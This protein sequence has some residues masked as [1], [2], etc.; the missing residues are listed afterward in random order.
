MTQLKRFENFSTNEHQNTGHAEDPEVVAFLAQNI[1]D[2]R[3]IEGPDGLMYKGTNVF[4]FY[5]SEEV[6]QELAE[7]AGIGSRD[8]E[9]DRIDGQEVYLGYYPELD[10]F[11]C[12]FDM[13]GN[14]G[15]G[16]YFVYFKIDDGRLD[17][18]SGHHGEASGI[19][20]PKNY[21]LLHSGGPKLIDIRLD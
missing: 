13:F 3:G 17:I 12:G 7:K 10:Q 15:G 16:S 18:K 21:K 14:D 1:E 19:V 2:L 5:V 6:S 8:E 9:G 20:Y 11:V 4:D